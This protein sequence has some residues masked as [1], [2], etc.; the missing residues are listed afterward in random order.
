MKLCRFTATSS[1]AVRI[2]LIATD[3]T[4]L[5]LAD[6]QANRGAAEMQFLGYADQ[7]TQV[8]QFHVG[9]YGHNC[10]NSRGVLVKCIGVT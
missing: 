2:V 10:S 1:P 8:S 4:V 5:D 6:V 7:K 9:G 3:R